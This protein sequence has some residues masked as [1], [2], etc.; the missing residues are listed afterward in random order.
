M[1]GRLVAR[2]YVAEPDLWPTSSG[3]W[4]TVHDLTPAGEPPRA[5]FWTTQA[6]TSCFD[7]RGDLVDDL[8]LEWAGDRDL[9]AA[10]TARPGSWC[11][12]RD[13]GQR[14]P[15]PPSGPDRPYVITRRPA[16]SPSTGLA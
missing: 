10:I 16:P 2:G 12:S 3:G 4:Q 1:F 5:L 6:H 11:G 8:A 15:A 9:I 14:L 13:R 7:A